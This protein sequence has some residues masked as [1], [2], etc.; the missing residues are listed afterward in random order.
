[1]DSALETLKKKKEV[2]KSRMSKKQIALLD[3]H[4]KKLTDGLSSIDQETPELLKLWDSLGNKLP[5]KILVESGLD[6]KTLSKIEKL[7]DKLEGKSI[8]DIKQILKNNNITNVSDELVESF[9][10]AASK[11]EL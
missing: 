3:N 1:M 2:L 10:K 9:S 8:D 6:T 5:K 7:I 4:I 11:A